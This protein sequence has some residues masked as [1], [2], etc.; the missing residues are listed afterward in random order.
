ML[1]S[2]ESKLVLNLDLSNLLMRTMQK[3][4]VRTRSYQNAICQNRHLFAGKVVL[5]VGCGTAILVCAARAR[6]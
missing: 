2:V 6:Y 3:D 1:V 5:D 4:E